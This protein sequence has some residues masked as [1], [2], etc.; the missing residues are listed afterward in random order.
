MDTSGLIGATSLGIQVFQLFGSCLSGYQELLAVF[1]KESDLSMLRCRLEIEIQRFELWGNAA[2]ASNGFDISTRHAET[3]I[4]TLRCLEELIASGGSLVSKHSETIHGQPSGQSD[5]ISSGFKCIAK[6]ASWLVTDKKKFENIVSD[7]KAINDSLISLLRE[8]SARQVDQSFYKLAIN[9]LG[10]DNFSKL[11]L[12]QSA[13][14]ETYTEICALA[15]LKALKLSLDHAEN[16]ATIQNGPALEPQP[17]EITWIHVAEADVDPDQLLARKVLDRRPMLL[18][19]RRLPKSPSVRAKMISRMRW[20]MAFLAQAP[21]LKDLRALPVYGATLDTGQEYVAMIYQHPEAIWDRVPTSLY[22]LLESPLRRARLPSLNQR[23][24]LATTLAKALLQL[25]TGGWVHK[26]ISSTNVIFFCPDNS[27]ASPNGTSSD[28]VRAPYLI[29]YGY[30]RVDD[31]MS[32]SN[33]DP[34]FS[35]TLPLDHHADLYR[36]PSTFGTSKSRNAFKKTYDIYS[37]GIILLEIA[38]WKTCAPAV[39]GVNPKDVRRFLTDKYL[40]GNL[41]YRVGETYQEV[42]RTCLTGDFGDPGKEKNWL[43]V[44]FLERVVRRLEI[45]RP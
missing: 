1:D 22:D 42:V 31:M 6:Q 36:H 38:L 18:N 26:S 21:R 33:S 37:L 3:V 44:Q 40:E 5:T 30:S 12:L 39:A 11:N 32:L 23:I 20:T 17:P 29:G 35:E 28:F 27:Q 13:T 24:S 45:C 43:Q 4:S 25:H 41:A 14:S 9:V 8:S 16:L 34:Q 7:V 2:K 15:A 19:W 10:T